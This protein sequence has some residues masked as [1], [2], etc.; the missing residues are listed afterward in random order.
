M[1]LSLHISTE[2][3]QCGVALSAITCQCLTP[4]YWFSGLVSLISCEVA[5]VPSHMPILDP[6]LVVSWI[7]VLDFLRSG[8]RPRPGRRAAGSSRHATG[9]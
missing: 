2:I 8:V 9:A 5:S 7:G 6:M 4:C 1:T 3:M